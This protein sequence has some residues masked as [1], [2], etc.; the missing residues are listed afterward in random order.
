VERAPGQQQASSLAVHV[1]VG[2]APDRQHA[3][4]GETQQVP[5]PDATQGER[6]G[7]D[8]RERR[9]ERPEHG[10]PLA[11]PAVVQ[12]QPAVA[13]G[14]RRLVEPGRRGLGRAVQ[15]GGGAVEPGVGEH[16]RGVRPPQPP[17]LEV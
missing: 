2:E 6:S 12:A 10:S 5:P 3:E 7:A 4:A 17:L 1:L 14:R 11:D 16:G 15:H 8:P 13:V 9:H